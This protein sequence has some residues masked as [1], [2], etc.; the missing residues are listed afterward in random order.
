LERRAPGYVIEREDKGGTLNGEERQ[1]GRENIKGHSFV[2][3]M[4]D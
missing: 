1:L 2:G 3:E 4:K